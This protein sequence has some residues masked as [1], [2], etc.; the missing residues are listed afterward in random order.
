MSLTLI[1]PALIV[2]AIGLVLAYLHPPMRPS[3]EARLLCT[4]ATVAGLTG[5]TILFALTA[6]LVSRTDLGSLIVS[7]CPALPIGHGVG[8]VE[9]L[10]GSALLVAG[11]ARFGLTLRQRRRLSRATGGRRFAVIDSSQPTAFAV[12][13]QPGCVVVS[14]GLLDRVT[15]QQRRV[16]LAHEQAHLRHRHHRHLL[17][18][19][20]VTSFVPILRPLAARIRL[21]TEL[22]ADQSAVSAIGND[23]G[24]VARTIETVAALTSSPSSA[25]PAFGGSAIDARLAALWAPPL[26]P[27]RRMTGRLAGISAL[28]LVVATATTQAH[29]LAEAVWHICGM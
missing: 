18:G 27:G 21:V 12:P 10:V 25:V 5:F 3:A 28:L 24:L 2:V 1:A 7:A 19:E 20:F 15:P 13:G 8:L 16:V 14:R 26:G 9:G 23:A 4:Y 11:S 22:A 17:A 29:H 6:G